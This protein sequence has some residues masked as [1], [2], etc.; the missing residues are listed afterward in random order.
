MAT[1]GMGGD[2]VP[3]VTIARLAEHGGRTVELAGWVYNVRSK[4]K[5]HFLLFRDGTGIVQA[6]CVQGQVDPGLFAAVGHLSQESSALLR[7]QVRAEDRK[8]VV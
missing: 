6:V 3:R 4:G 2:A 8:S 7:G 5:I 1:S